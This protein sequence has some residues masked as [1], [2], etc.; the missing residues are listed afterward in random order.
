MFFINN[1]YGNRR[2]GVFGFS[3]LCTFERLGKSSHKLDIDISRI[4]RKTIA[5][6]LKIESYHK[7]QTANFKKYL[8]MSRDGIVFQKK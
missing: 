5:I 8:N 6:H 3:V 4:G 7:M 1:L 2:S